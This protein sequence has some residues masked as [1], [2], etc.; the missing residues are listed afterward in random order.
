MLWGPGLL[1]AMLAA[2]TLALTVSGAATPARGPVEPPLILALPVPAAT[3][4]PPDAARAATA[5]ALALVIGQTGPVTWQPSI[6]FNDGVEDAFFAI[7]ITGGDF[8]AVYLTTEGA[9]Q[10]DPDLPAAV[11]QLESE[12]IRL[13]DDGSHGDLVAADGVFSRGGITAV[14]PLTHD[15]GTHQRLNSRLFFFEQKPGQVSW[16]T[17]TMESGIGV[18]DRSQRGAAPVV[19]LGPNL[20]TTSHALFLVDDGSLFPNYPA[21]DA[22]TAVQSASSA[23]S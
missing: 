16:G 11:L 4:G 2:I 23:R 21:V 8:D 7:A 3:H 1:G 15:A 14:G 6:I 9:L 22:D 17:L 10:P 18:V 13:Y 20:T 12:L 19:T 5:S